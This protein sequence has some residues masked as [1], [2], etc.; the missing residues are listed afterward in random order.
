MA[1]KSSPPPLTLE[2]FSGIMAAHR[3]WLD[4]GGHEGQKAELAGANLEG[5]D[6]SGYNLSHLDFRGANLARVKFGDASVEGANFKAA[7]LREAELS[8]VRGL[9]APQLAGADLAGARLPEDLQEFA[10][11]KHVDAAS[12]HVQKIFFLLLLVCV[13]CGLTIAVT[14]D[15]NLLNNFAETPLPIIGTKINLVM[16]YWAAPFLLLCIYLYFQLCLQRL[17][18]ALVELPAVFTDGLPLPH[19]V[20]PWLWNGLVWAYS[21]RLRDCRPPLLGLQKKL[22]EF[23]VWWAGPLTILILW[24]RYLPAHHW[25]ITVIQ[26]L[27]LTLSLSWALSFYLLTRAT[28]ALK[29]KISPLTSFLIRATL[30]RE[31]KKP[32]R[33]KLGIVASAISEYLF[34]SVIMALLFILSRG[35]IDG[36]GNRPWVRADLREADVS[37][38]PPQWTGK[39]AD[40]DLVRGA[41]LRRRNLQDAAA[42]EAFLVKADLSEADL[43]YADLSGANLQQANLSFADLRGADLEE[44]NLQQANLEWAKLTGANLDGTDFRE[45]KGLE[46]EQVLISFCWPLAKYSQESLKTL[47]LPSDHNERLNKKDLSGYQLP[48]TELREA[49]LHE[50]NIRRANLLFANLVYAIL[51]RAN[52][53]QANLEGA[54]LE[55]ASLSGANLQQANLSDAELQEAYLEGADFQEAKGL[56]RDQV[57][58]AHCWPLAKYSPEMVT[59]LGFP[60]E[61]NER[62]NKKDLSGY[63]L[64]GAD[65]S[66]GIGLNTD[67]KGFNLRGA[68][69][70]GA[71]LYCA[72]LTGSNLTGSALRGA[73]LFRANLKGADLRGADLKEA[74]LHN[75]N[76]EGADLRGAKGLTREQLKSAIMDENTK[77]PEDLK[78][79]VPSRTKKPQEN[80]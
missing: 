7:D 47:G 6:L 74:D 73:V 2:D 36:L 24:Y 3:Q 15:A 70:Q 23:L 5:L 18:E 28:L 58:A 21:P 30:D 52:L 43:Q 66:G 69:L 46:K 40:L 42:Y 22:A 17:W 49:N 16:F 29:E 25:P 64:A 56:E 75:A 8:G 63:H 38:K 61:H 32:I 1:Q 72:D 11:L 33:S 13:Y 31:E 76:L 12:S 39:A 35:S 59:T 53:Q 54:N 10:G 14:T 55:G 62:L 68:N 45:A 51:V 4:S 50:F 67:L 60:P 48:R 19:R 41:S 80:K 77:L 57:R 26:M 9:L 79:L 20:H 44:A 34:V 78:D 71:N 37:L 27:L 65:L